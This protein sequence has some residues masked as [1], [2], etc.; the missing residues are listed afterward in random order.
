MRKI[1]QYQACLRSNKQMSAILE[2]VSIFYISKFYATWMI[3]HFE[4]DKKANTVEMHYEW[5]ATDKQAKCIA[6]TDWK[7]KIS[8]IQKH[9]GQP[10]GGISP[11]QWMETSLETG[12]YNYPLKISNVSFAG[13]GTQNVRKTWWWHKIKR[14][15]KGTKRALRITSLN[16]FPL[17]KSIWD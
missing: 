2:M 1:V 12:M 6:R 9:A 8:R 13:I 5:K 16:V 10:S 17:V 11:I 7:M 3:Y 15:D 4:H 14:L